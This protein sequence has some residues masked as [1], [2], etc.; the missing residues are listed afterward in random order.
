MFKKVAARH[1]VVVCRHAQAI[2]GRAGEQTLEGL[3]WLSGET[4]G[5]ITPGGGGGVGESEM[6][7]EEEE[8]TERGSKLLL[9]NSKRFQEERKKGERGREGERREERK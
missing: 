4:R 8:E 9:C 5:E 2:V 1:Q 6:K 3:S 7:R